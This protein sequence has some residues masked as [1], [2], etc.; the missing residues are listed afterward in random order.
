MKN[1]L[2]FVRDSINSDVIKNLA[3]EISS[4]VVIIADEHVARLYGHD[5]KRHLHQKQKVDL[6]TFPS[7]E[8]SKTRETKAQIEDQL[9]EL[10]L[11][12]DGALIAL[13]GGVTTDLTGFIAATY[14][15]GIPYLSIPTTLLGM[16]DASIG[17]KTGVN[18]PG[19]KNMIG[20]FYS[21]L[22]VIIDMNFLESLGKNEWRGGM[23]EVI[24]YGAILDE[25]LFHE[26]LN[27]QDWNLNYLG[28]IIEKSARIKTL[29]VEKDPTEKGLRRILNFGHT[30]GHAI[31]TLENY[32][33]S[34]G[35][36]VS[37]GMIGEAHLTG[38]EAPL[39]EIMEKLEFPLKLSPNVTAKALFEVMKKDKKAENKV[40]RFVQLENLG[41]VASFDGKY[42]TE[43]D[44]EPLLHT[45]NWMIKWINSR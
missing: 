43:I 41:K 11:G 45:L 38:H 1:K 15:R 33:I 3:E 17:G 44:D 27:F 13:G 16:V 26:L 36:A 2:Q 25:A 18:L 5:L 32:N 14:C 31:E 23:A 10:G 35:D 40:A 39:I 20:A 9:F 6:I 22:K 28:P 12:R 19:G 30:I 8:Q 24:K 37:I 7:G 34:H 42:C 29:V 21:P 4:H